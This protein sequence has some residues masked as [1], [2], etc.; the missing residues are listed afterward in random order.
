METDHIYP[1]DLITLY[2]AGEAGGDDLIFLESWLKADP[3]NRKI[4][5]DYRKTWLDMEKIRMDK[6]LDTDKEWNQ[7]QHMLF[8]EESPKQ[9]RV[10][11]FYYNKVLRVAAI[12][13]LLVIPSIYFV[14]YLIRPEQKQ[15]DASLTIKEG[16]LPD[17]TSVTLNKGTTLEYP[18][19]FKGNNRNVTLKGEAFFE[20][21]HDE[22]KPFIVK[23][24][25]IRIEVLGT[26]FYV[27]TNAGNNNIEVVLN[28]GSVAIYFDDNRKNSLFLSPGEKAEINTDQEK[29]SKDVNTDPNYRS[30]MTRHF[31][32]NNEP[33]A[34]IIA[35]LNKVY[36][37]N[38]KIT[39]LSISN[40]LVTATFDHQS[41]ESILH[42][43]QATLDLNINNHGS[44][45]EI[46]GKKCN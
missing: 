8:I 26:S 43:L 45:I 39:T 38:L 2:L 16:K 22:T 34:V 9:G 37:S 11:S 24:R 44:W 27:N 1:I 41:M 23:S 7:L 10:I 32:Y 25:N 33:L 28:S 13:L 4:F 29:M 30:W 36:H 18:A 35:D 40:C 42:V 31:S 17:G 6:D 19:V 12:I 14:R 5:E 46:S 15:L 21:K 3:G 20:V